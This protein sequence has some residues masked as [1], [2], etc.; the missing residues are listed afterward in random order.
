M[1]ANVVRYAPIAIRAARVL[2]HL[3]RLYEE[4]TPQERRDIGD[5]LQAA[6]VV[7]TKVASRKQE[8]PDLPDM[9][10]LLPPEIEP[11]P[12]G[13]RRYEKKRLRERTRR[14]RRDA[15]QIVRIIRDYQSGFTMEDSKEIAMHLDAIWKT[16]SEV[17]RR[18][19]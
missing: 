1:V 9:L 15:R 11:A 6:I 13:P 12:P 18:V 2:H 3:A 4:S 16:L 14:F 5:H 8:S 17:N 7:L 10:M 19:R